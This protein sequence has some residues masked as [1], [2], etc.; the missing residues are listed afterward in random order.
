MSDAV[1]IA[2]ASLLSV[3]ITQL[4]AYLI[5]KNKIKAEKAK[6][7]AETGKIEA[8]TDLTEGEI[9]EKYQRIAA[10]TADENIKLAKAMEKRE[11]EFAIEKETFTKEIGKLKKDFRELKTAFEELK[12]DNAKWKDYAQRL[13]Y[14]LKSFDVIPVPLDLSDIKTTIIDQEEM[15]KQSKK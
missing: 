3:G 14:Q 13:I 15:E 6:N 2:I 11:E 7:E 5:N 4:I 9:I 1:L 12:I 8:D 10:R